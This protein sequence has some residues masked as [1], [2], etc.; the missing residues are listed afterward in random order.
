MEKNG[1]NLIRTQFLG[2]TFMRALGFLSGVYLSNIL[3]LLC[4]STLCHGF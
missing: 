3:G 4:Y 1:G 2:G